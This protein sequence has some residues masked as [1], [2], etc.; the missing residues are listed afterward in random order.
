MPVKAG[1][2]LTKA[3]TL[4]VLAGL[5]F[6]VCA[7]SS[8]SVIRGDLAG[9]SAEVDNIMIQPVAELPIPSEVAGLRLAGLAQGEKAVAV[10]E[11]FIGT[12]YRI[13][14]TSIIT[15][16]GGAD[17]LIFWIVEFWEESEAVTVLDKMKLR[18]NKSLNFRD[19]KYYSTDYSDIYYACFNGKDAP[20]AHSYYYRKGN[21]VFWISMRQEMPFDTLEPF[22]C[23]F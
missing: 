10:M 13:K 19:Q 7:C 22:I 8:G 11:K 15:Y 5:T 17:E 4:I 3:I 1:F 16:Q 2:F 18:I 6:A 14:D 21:R 23:M 12:E 9:I 20:F